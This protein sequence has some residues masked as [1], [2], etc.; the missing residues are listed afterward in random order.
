MSQRTGHFARTKTPEEARLGSQLPEGAETDSVFGKLMKNFHVWEND[1][2]H[3]IFIYY[4]IYIY[5]Y[6]F[7]ANT[8]Q[9]SYIYK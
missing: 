3:P 8:V 5:I 9:I 6:L 7:A 4:C 2:D 1:L